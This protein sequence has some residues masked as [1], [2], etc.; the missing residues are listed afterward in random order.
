MI[1]FIAYEKILL[2]KG[3]VGIFGF[4]QFLGRFFGFCT[5][6][7]RFLDFVGRCSFRFFGFFSTRFFGKNKAG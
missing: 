3:D 7:L 5:E 4:G 1:L 6:K 2:D